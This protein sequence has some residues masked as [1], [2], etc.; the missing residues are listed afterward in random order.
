MHKSECASED[1]LFFCLFLSMLSVSEDIVPGQYGL[2]HTVTSPT[3]DKPTK[4]IL[5]TTYNP[6]PGHDVIPPVGCYDVRLLQKHYRK[7]FRFGLTN[8]QVYVTDNK[9]YGLGP[10]FS[11]SFSVPISEDLKTE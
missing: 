10:S 11:E 4:T 3:I 6:H 2:L 8:Q 5:E 1:H 7:N 9:I